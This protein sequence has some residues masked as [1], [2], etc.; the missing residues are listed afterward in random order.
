MSIH[1]PRPKVTERPS[2][3]EWVRV[4]FFENEPP[5]HDS[6]EHHA[7]AEVFLSH[8]EAALWRQHREELL[9]EW[10]REHPGTRPPGWWLYEAPKDELRRVLP[11]QGVRALES[12]YFYTEGIPS[13]TPDADDEL[14]FVGKLKVESQA[15]FLRRHRLFLEGEAKR[16]K[17]AAYRPELVEWDLD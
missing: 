4:W 1:R 7:Y 9:E 11:G 5:A 15:S 3:P 10:V 2:C 6:A 13:V 17:P 12:A 8:G 14:V 16:L